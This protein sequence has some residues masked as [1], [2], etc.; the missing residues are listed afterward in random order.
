[1][2]LFFLMADEYTV[3]LLDAWWVKITIT[4]WLNS[5]LEMV[6]DHCACNMFWA[7]QAQNMLQENKSHEHIKQVLFMSITLFF[8]CESFT[9]GLI[10]LIIDLSYDFPCLQRQIAR[11]LAALRRARL[12]LPRRNLRPP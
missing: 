10:F 1:M 2:L 12:T 11:S 7:Y 3:C 6:A 5:L 8:F 9:H 4:T